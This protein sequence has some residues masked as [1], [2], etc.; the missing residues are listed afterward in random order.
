ME[1]EVLTDF[2][3]RSERAKRGRQTKR[4]PQS[5]DQIDEEFDSATHKKRIPVVREALAVLD[6]KDVSLEDR[7][8]ALQNQRKKYAAMAAHKE[9]A[10]M[11]LAAGGSNKQAAAKAG[12]SP[13]QVRKY[14]TDPDFRARIEELRTTVLSKVR[15]RLMKE[16]ERRTKPGSIER[17]ELLDLLRIY[18]RVVGPGKNAGV[19][20][21][22]DVNVNQSNH[23]TIIAAL[24]APVRSGEE[25]DFPHYEPSDLR[26]PGDGAPE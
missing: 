1:G 25:P 13:R 24:L 19:N 17:I 21:A 15:G 6:P 8:E 2:E 22:G 11:V 20:I 9:M 10:A 26:L 14:M 12:V 4:V 16:L 23:D 7:V 3:V 18:D 5:L